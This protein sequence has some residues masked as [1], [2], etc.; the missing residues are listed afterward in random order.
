M[1]GKADSVDALTA[2][3]TIPFHQ[4]FSSYPADVHSKCMEKPDGYS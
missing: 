4:G 1:Y 2:I 3:G